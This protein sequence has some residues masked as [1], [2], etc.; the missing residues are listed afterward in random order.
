MDK[1]LT[2]QVNRPGKICENLE[3]L[4]KEELLVRIKSLQ[5]HNFQLK[6]ILSKTLN[7]KQTGISKCQK[8]FDFTRY[9]TRHILLKIF[10]LGW[11]YQGFAVQENTNDTIEHHLFN[12]L[13]RTC[14]IQDRM[15]S[16]YH[17][18]GRTDKGV[19]SFGQ[20]ISITIRSRLCEAD[21]DKLEQEMNYCK[22]LNRV[23]P[24]EIRCVS[25]KPAPKEFSARFDC[26]SRTYKYFFPL[27]N[28]NIQ[29][30]KEAAKHFLGA[31]DFRNF[32]KMDV[33]NGVVEFIRNVEKIEIGPVFPEQNLEEYSMFVITIKSGGFLWHQIRCMLGILFLIGQNKESPTVI[34]ELLNVKDNPCKPD[35][36]MASEIPLNLYSA[37]YEL[38][39]DWQYEEENLRDV[40]ED[41]R[42]MWSFSAI[43][44]N[45]MRVMID[46]LTK[47]LKTSDIKC[48]SENFIQGVK[49]KNYMPLMKRQK[50]AS[51]EK[52]ISHYVKRCR[53][54]INPSEEKESK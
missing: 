2:I 17:R 11:D 22:M 39:V 23:L 38:D 15:T 4:S 27:G 42:Q 46:D 54:S 10:Y 25:W 21:Q 1:P 13:I 48:L 29:N 8:S 45:M 28:L 9:N 12:A 34:N 14:L 33:G 44:S 37:D 5:A 19:S 41:L 20:V 52:K 7:E 32:C 43:K 18:C 31:H 47:E 49:P 40:V 51:L 24:K 50:C 30:M 53:L 16:N 36:N 3:D 35:Y 26:K 6:N